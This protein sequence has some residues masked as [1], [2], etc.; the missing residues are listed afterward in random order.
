MGYH[1]AGFEVV[2]VDL[3]PQPR[4]PFEFWR[5]DALE[6]LRNLEAVVGNFDAIHASPPCQAYS[7]CQRIRDREHPALIARTRK[8][9]IATGL[10]YVIEN[11]AGAR[12]ELEDPFILC[13]AM[14]GL[15]TYRHRYFETNF[16]VLVPEHPEH[17]WRQA[18]M[19]RPPGPSEFIQCV[20]NFS[21]VAFGRAAMEMP[22]ANRDGLREA[23]PPAYTEHIGRAL[24]RA[25]K[26]A[27][28]TTSRGQS[29]A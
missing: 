4:Y 22:W 28:L 27:R 14:F 10:P 3:D 16:P 25:V 9:L 6:V 5:A 2:G 21:G 1:R 17:L 23:I 29:D 18:K 12:A 13:G 15:P 26:V 19:G 8:R 11:V 24:M 20:G 7:D